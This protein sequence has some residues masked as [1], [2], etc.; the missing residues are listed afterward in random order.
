MSF[1]TPLSTAWPA[2]VALVVLV[3]ALWTSRRH[4]SLPRA[5]VAV[6]AAALFVRL[7]VI[8]AMTDHVYDGHEADYFDLFRG[9]REPTRGGTVMVPG[10]QWLWWGLGRVLPG[11]PVIPVLLMSLV[12]VAAIGLVAGAV[13]VLSGRSAGW[14][15]V[16][17]LIVHPTHAAWSTSAYNVMLPHALGGLALFATALIARRAGPLGG[18]PWLAAGAAALMVALRLDT[19]TLVWPL[20]LLPILIRP[21][22]V[23]M[24]RRLQQLVPAGLTGAALAGLAAWPLLWP[25]D[26]PGAGERGISFEI[27]V[28]LMDYYT[29]FDSVAGLGMV[30]VAAVL[31]SRRQPLVALAM[32]PMILGHHLLLATF[33]DFGTRHTLPTLV[34]LVWCLGAAAVAVPRL[35]WLLVLA[36][37]ILSTR[38]L[39]DLAER[40][41]GDEAAFN[42]VLE[43]SPWDS[44]PRVRWPGDVDP[45]CGWVTE[46]HRVRRGRAASHFNLIRPE[47]EQALRGPDGCLRW[48]L[49]VQD[50]RW[51]S[52]GVRD[53]AFRLRHMFELT[54]AFVVEE[55]DT[56]YAC[57]AMDVGQRRYGTAPTSHETRPSDESHNRAHRH[58][59]P[60]P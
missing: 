50:W 53:R 33:D 11:L 43:Q 26:L 38:Q 32:V 6:A 47:E 14:A 8:P 57:L 55:R 19:A 23:S 44:L 3:A 22:G 9:A 28:G 17:V 42:S 7:V 60:I 51:S 13:G 58:D 1:E 2:G 46:D 27:N 24:T 15:A 48:C 30:A 29:P 49:D 12:S 36:S 10:M 40:Y 31:A 21:D 52:R 4:F 39:S 20:V 16:A 18:L 34:P 35:G 5:W 25:G 59:S 37:V 45:T 54:P 56:G 41:Y